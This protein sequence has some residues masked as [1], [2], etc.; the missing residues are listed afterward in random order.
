ME[1]EIEKKIEEE[2]EKEVGL[3]REPTVKD[4]IAI[5]NIPKGDYEKYMQEEF[6]ISPKMLKTVQKAKEQLINDTVRITGYDIVDNKDLKESIMNVKTESGT[7]KTRFNRE[8][9]F[10]NPQNGKEIKKP[11]VQLTMRMK[12]LI[13]KDL[14]GKLEEEIKKQV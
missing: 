2:E 11:S 10:R 4:G 5:R 1:K 14:L 12:S 13:D 8:K 9:T 6:K 3:D 7:L